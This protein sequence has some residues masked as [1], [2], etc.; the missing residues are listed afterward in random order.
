[1]KNPLYAQQ[2]LTY[3]PI[4]TAGQNTELQPADLAIMNANVI[5]L[6][7][8]ETIHETKKI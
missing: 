4:L 5:D 6:E 3:P 1:M 7:F 2:F 8:G